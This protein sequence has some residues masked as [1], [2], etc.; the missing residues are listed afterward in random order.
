M[1]VLVEILNGKR[2]S[3]QLHEQIL[4]PGLAGLV[5]NS[6]VVSDKFLNF[7]KGVE[8]TVSLRGPKYWLKKVEATRT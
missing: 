6:F 2:Y 3:R 7:Y 5:T 8:F 1:I 4:R